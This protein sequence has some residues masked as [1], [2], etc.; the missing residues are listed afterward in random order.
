MLRED[1][2]LASMKS[3]RRSILRAAVS[4]LGLLFVLG[5]W[6]TAPLLLLP[7][8]GARKDKEAEAAPEKG[9]SATDL[10]HPQMRNDTPLLLWALCLSCPQSNHACLLASL[11]WFARPAQRKACLHSV[12]LFGRLFVLPCLEAS[13]ATRTLDRLLS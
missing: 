7:Y 10:H 5:R 13:F 12:R 1:P 6:L 11:V 4:R 2:V 3:K 8:P 9:S